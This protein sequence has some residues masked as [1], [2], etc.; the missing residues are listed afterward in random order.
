MPERTSEAME[1]ARKKAHARR[2][3]LSYDLKND[4]KLFYK[5]LGAEPSKLGKQNE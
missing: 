5:N 3:P 2:E 1:D 4:K